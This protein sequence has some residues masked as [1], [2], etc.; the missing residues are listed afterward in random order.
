MSF[1][2]HLRG[3]REGAGLSRAELAR[4][5]RVPATTLRGWEGD[6]GFPTLPALLRLAG[7]LGVPVERLAEGVEDPAEGEGE[8]VLKRSRG[9]RWP[10]VP[11]LV[12]DT[13]ATEQQAVPPVGQDADKMPTAQHKPKRMRA[14]GPRG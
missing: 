7:A 10:A 6:R 14:R 8:P 11:A 1:G 9:A 4:Q 2:S 12:V 3:L 5:A 13:P